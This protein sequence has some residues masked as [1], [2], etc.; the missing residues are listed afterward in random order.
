MQILLTVWAIAPSDVNGFFMLGSH[1][2]AWHV[3]FPVVP[4][5]W[6]WDHFGGSYGGFSDVSLGNLCF[7]A[8]VDFK[9]RI[10]FGKRVAAVA[11]FELSAI[12]K[13]I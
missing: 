3:S 7:L 6:S 9:N 2:V 11:P 1:I 12:R 10:G 4:H 8:T 13:L 5:M